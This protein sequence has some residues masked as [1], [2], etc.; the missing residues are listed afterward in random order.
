MNP[1]QWRKITDLFE[2]AL[3]LSAAE[4]AAFL[5]RACDDDDELRLRIEEMLAADAR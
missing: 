4:R 2:A 3:D 1:E 5:E